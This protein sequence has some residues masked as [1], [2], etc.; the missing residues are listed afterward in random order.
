AG[1]GCPAALGTLG[2]LRGHRPAPAEAPVSFARESA[3]LR[4]REIEERRGF[5]GA[6]RTLGGLGGHLAALADVPA[7]FARES[8]RLRIREIEE[9]RGFPKALRTLG[10]WAPFRGSR[11][12]P[13][14]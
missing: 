13:G 3:R 7:S 4:I 11:R 10:V 14:F 6:L 8:A 2:G 9:R 5:P 1:R 12:C